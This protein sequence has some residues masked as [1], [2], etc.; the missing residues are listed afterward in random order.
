MKRP[1]VSPE[2]EAVRSER[3]AASACSCRASCDLMTVAEDIQALK[4]LE[5]E[6]VAEVQSL[7]RERLPDTPAAIEELC[8]VIHGVFGKRHFAAHLIA[9]LANDRDLTAVRLKKAVD[10]L[11]RPEASSKKISH[12]L[13]RSIGTFCPWRL[14]FHKMGPEKAIYSI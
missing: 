1:T 14:M 12:F 3:H 5:V 4:L 11:I 6:L 10:R 13:A 7:R 9:E 2:S 8:S